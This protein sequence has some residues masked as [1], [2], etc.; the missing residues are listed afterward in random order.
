MKHVI[1]WLTSGVN[2]ASLTV[3]TA[4]EISAADKGS[5]G[6]LDWNPAVVVIPV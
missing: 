3:A 2:P 4:T 5:R 1:V 6:W